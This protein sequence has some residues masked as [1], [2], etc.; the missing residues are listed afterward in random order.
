VEVHAIHAC[1][2]RGRYADDRDDRQHLEDV[3]LLDADETEDRIQQELRLAGEM[4][5]EV[6]YAADMLAAV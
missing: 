1:D 2:Q 5:L 3:V 4:G 6:D